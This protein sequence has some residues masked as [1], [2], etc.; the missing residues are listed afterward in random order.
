MRTFI[1]QPL[2]IVCKTCTCPFSV[3]FI[4]A[5][6]EVKSREGWLQSFLRARIQA[7]W[8]LVSLWLLKQD[9]TFMCHGGRGEQ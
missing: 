7:R 8:Q 3:L 5:A 2:L 9:R 6:V 4:V 1:R